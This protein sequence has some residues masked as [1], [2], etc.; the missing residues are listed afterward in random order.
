MSPCH[1]SLSNIF[2]LVLNLHHLHTINL[3][4]FR[5][6]KTV[7]LHLERLSSLTTLGSLTIPAKDVKLFQNGGFPNL[8]KLSVTTDGWS[9][10]AALLE[11]LP[12][13][14]M[15]L[16]VNCSVER[17][18]LSMLRGFTKASQPSFGSLSVIKLYGSTSS[19]VSDVPL[20]A[21]A[22]MSDMVRP[23]FSIKLRDVSLHFP[24]MKLLGDSQLDKITKAWPLL[25][26]TT[27][28]V[29][30]QLMATFDGLISFVRHCPRLRKINLSIDITAWEPDSYAVENYCGINLQ[31][32][33]LH[34][35]GIPAN[36][37]LV[38][39]LQKVF[40]RLQS[41]VLIDDFTNLRWA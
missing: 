28:R 15:S 27:L 17:E 35:P 36:R 14:F 8:E 38:C 32:L 12:C 31:N 24:F 41:W 1:E 18:P 29:K 9:S 4:G 11:S 20:D 37:Q 2:D 26:D 39:S 33:G 3:F 22:V 25:E 19:F 10:S 7:V 16:S 23:L 34:H 6:P 40:P 30:E 21:E 5:L 13:A